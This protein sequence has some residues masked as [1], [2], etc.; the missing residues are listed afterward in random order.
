MNKSEYT[1]QNRLNVNRITIE[2][3]SMTP[4]FNARSSV[5]SKVMKVCF[6]MLL[7]ITGV[8]PVLQGSAYF[9]E[10]RLSEPIEIRPGETD[11][12]FYT[13]Q[14]GVYGGNFNQATFSGFQPLYTYQLPNGFIRYSSGHYSTEREAITRLEKVI[15]EG[16]S[17]AFI[18]GTLDGIKMVFLPRHGRGHRFLPSDRFR[19]NRATRH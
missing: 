17:D 11:D 5:M 4:D 9:S 8:A 13:V 6:F 19:K 10:E 1:I 7:L 2:S 3:T 16:M 12:L 15:A 18:T 14:I